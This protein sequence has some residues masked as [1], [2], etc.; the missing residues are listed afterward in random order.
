MFLAEFQRGC[1]DIG[2]DIKKKRREK[3][4][5]KTVRIRLLLVLH[6][7]NI[8]V[9]PSSGSIDTRILVHLILF[10]SHAVAVYGYYII[11][12]P[13]K[14]DLRSIS[15]YGLLNMPYYLLTVLRTVDNIFRDPGGLVILLLNS[16]RGKL[17]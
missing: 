10:L 2:L 12:E 14:Y 3:I 1:R 11:P 5:S 8:A 4:R 13:C 16:V 7:N 6:N 17:Q 9:E 15:F